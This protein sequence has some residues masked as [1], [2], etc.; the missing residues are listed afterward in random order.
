MSGPLAWSYSSR[1]PPSL[2]RP[3]HVQRMAYMAMLERVRCSVRDINERNV[4]NGKMA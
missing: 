1:Q 4:G 2:D 3:S